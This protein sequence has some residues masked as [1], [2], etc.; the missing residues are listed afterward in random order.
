MNVEVRTGNSEVICLGIGEYIIRLEE[1]GGKE[2]EWGRD[3]TGTMKNPYPG[4][5]GGGECKFVSAA[6]F[7]S[8]QVGRQPALGVIAQRGQG[9]CADEFRVV[10]HVKSFGKINYIL[11][12]MRSEGQG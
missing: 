4:M 2:V 10:D 7:T 8:L 1:C 9:E 6:G 3:N 5:K 11:V 12:N